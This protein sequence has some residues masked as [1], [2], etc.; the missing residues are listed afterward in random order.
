M[1]RKFVP[2]VNQARENHPHGLTDPTPLVNYIMANT[3]GGVAAKSAKALASA[4]G[5]AIYLTPDQWT[6]A[7]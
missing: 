4:A 1:R 6:P 3:A 2:L 7:N 5:S